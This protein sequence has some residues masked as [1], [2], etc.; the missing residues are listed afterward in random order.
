MLSG[1]LR[2]RRTSTLRVRDR[3][4]FSSPLAPSVSTKRSLRYERR[5]VAEDYDN[6]QTS[7]EDEEEAGDEDSEENGP[8]ENNVEEDSTGTSDEDGMGESTPLLPIFSALHLDALPVYNLTHAIRLLVVAR[9]ETTLSWDQLRSPQVSQFMLKPIQQEIRS[10]HFS[11]ATQCALMA[12]CLQFQKEA[13]ANPGNS[14]ASKTRAMVC[15]LLAIRLLKEYTTR[16]LIDALSYDFDPLQGQTNV[17]P[18]APGGIETAPKANWDASRRPRSARIS[19][20]EIAIRALAKRFLAH[21]LVVQ[22]LEAIWAG[23]IVFHSA[24]DNLHRRPTKAAPNQNRGYGTTRAGR[25]PQ[26]VPR[27]DADASKLQPAKQRS[28]MPSLEVT[29]RRAVTLYNPKDASLFKLSRLRVPRYR[30]LLSTG[31]FAV[32]L[33]LFLAV[34]IQ[35]SLEI[36]TLEIVFWFWAAGYM[37][38]EIIGF[39]EQGFSLYIASFWNTFDLGILIILFV[40]L[41]LR[42]YGIVL[43]DV[44]KHRM[45]NM[46]YDVLAADAI[47]L[48]PRLFSVLDHYRYFSQLLI[49]FRMMATDLIAI[50]VLIIISCSGFFVALTLSFGNEGIDTPGSVAYALLQILMGFTPAAWDRW[51]GY[52]ALGKTIL[53]LFLFICHFLVVT[54]LITVLTNSFMA[55]VQNANEEHQFVFAVNVISMIKSDSLFAY[56]APTNIIS[57]ILTPLRYFLPFRQ[58]VKINRTMIKVTHFPVLFIICAYERTILQASVVD[59]I[60][61]IEPRGRG[62]KAFKPK[63]PRLRRE[64]SVATIRQDR[65]LEEVFR[66]PFDSTMR[67]SH[68]SQERRKTSNVVSSWMRAVDEDVASP[69]AEQDQSVVE[70]LENRR[71]SQRGTSRRRPRTFIRPRNLSRFS[72]RSVAS[73]PEEFVGQDMFS[74]SPLPT[75]AQETPSQLDDPMQKNAAGGDDKLATFE[76]LNEDGATLDSRKSSTTPEKVSTTEPNIVR[77][78]DYFS[79]HGSSR[80]DNRELSPS[81][82]DSSKTQ[83]LVVVERSSPERQQLPQASEPRPNQHLRNTSTATIIFKPIHDDAT[84][85][86]SSQGQ[87]N[88]RPSSASGQS[89]GHVSALQSGAQTPSSKQPSTTTAG[90]AR[91]H[92]RGAQ[93][94]PRLRP[95]LPTKDNAGFTSAPNLAGL[96]MMNERQSEQRRPSLDVELISDIGDNKPMG[97]GYVGALPASFA[98][99]MAYATGG[100]NRYKERNEEHDMLSRIMMARMNSLEEGFREVV[101]EMRENMKRQGSHSRS[102]SRDR[103]RERRHIRAQARKVNELHDLKG[104]ADVEQAAARTPP[105]RLPAS[106]TVSRPES[107]RGELSKVPEVPKDTSKGAGSD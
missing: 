66:Q 32:L 7:D 71:A 12:N 14:G 40:H 16:E 10:N 63:L 2:P 77:P 95:L 6:V 69:P 86:P 96:V 85:Q 73:D 15:E 74:P 59:S 3:S 103:S 88:S 54:I 39:N 97:G 49:A 75:S 98:T 83:Q 24:A 42:I 89:K 70:R 13:G 50:F 99:Q 64:H 57:W 106:Q 58:Y 100:L 8:D 65:A 107:L 4:S 79:V 29:F 19:C 90:R 37:L 28:H 81:R 46:A 93:A 84:S 11:A 53:T 101:H 72:T 102:R 23:S 44:G 60:D 1:L 56:V 18:L 91:P 25:S 105:R 48:F 9:C 38:D 51:S 17:M 80:K 27:L 22:H 33:G 78:A 20:L 26:E 5:H 43:V 55:I 92:K 61:V 30:N 104:E 45:A 34:L 31:S 52:N 94:P 36:T 68:Q 87:H 76:K 47:L 82:K 35:R 21:P 67:T 41:C 62:G